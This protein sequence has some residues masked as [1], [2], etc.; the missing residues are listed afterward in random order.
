MTHLTVQGTTAEGFESIR[1][2]FEQNM[3]RYLEDKA[4]LCIYVDDHCVVDLW[5]SPAADTTFDGD[6]L[7]NIFS[8]GK[9]L[10]SIAM[11]W[12][13]SENRLQLSDQVTDYWPEYGA[14]GKAQQTIADVMRHEAGLAA[15]NQP[16]DPKD[17]HREQL[18]QK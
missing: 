15:L 12:L 16:L 11:A 8:S 4:Q 6:A 7:I 17:L 10:E 9:S 5:A 18:K 1:Q 2:L 14:A 3:R 13:V